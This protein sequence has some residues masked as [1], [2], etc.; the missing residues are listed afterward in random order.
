ML[1]AF[2]MYS[3]S[4]RE[5]TQAETRLIDVATRIAGIAIERKQAE[6]RIQFMANHDA[7]T[8][9]P[10]R[11][12]LKDRLTQAVLYRRAIRPLGDGGVHRSRQFQSWS[13]TASATTPAT[14]S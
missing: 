6:D 8:G 7:L 12:L 4:V 13:T 9:L 5:P 1:G 10:N 14:N 3:Q 11:A 2:A